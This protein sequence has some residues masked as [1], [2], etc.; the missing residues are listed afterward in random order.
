M[1]ADGSQMA[2]NAYG[3]VTGNFGWHMWTQAI[4]DGIHWTLS[5]TCLLCLLLLVFSLLGKWVDLD[6]TLNSP[7]SVGHVL[8]GTTGLADAGT[9]TLLCDCN[10]CLVIS[11]FT[12][13][14]IIRR[15]RR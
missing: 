5:S 12:F 2:G 15:P 8:L 3:G 10:M 14:C 11:C 7:Y 6:A 13:T 9:P 1:G 4:I